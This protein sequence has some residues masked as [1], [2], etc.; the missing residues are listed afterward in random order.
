MADE[1]GDVRMEN[2]QQQERM[3]T[4]EEFRQLQ[5][6]LQQQQ[7]ELQEVRRRNQPENVDNIPRPEGPTSELLRCEK[8]MSMMPKYSR[9]T[10]WRQYVYEW[11]SWVSAFR[12]EQAGDKFIKN[13]M[14][15]SMKGQAQ[16]AIRAHRAGSAT[17]NQ[18]VTWRDYAVAIESIFAPKAESQLAKQEFKGYKQNA[19]EDMTSYFQTKWALFKVA[20]PGD[21]S[22]FDIFHEELIKG[23]CNKEVTGNVA[24]L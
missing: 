12:I 11:E 8:A 16:D 9:T 21:Y 7:Q 15:L 13:A 2:G 4:V 23:I 6:Q 1:D 3:P 22:P 14:I 17:F 18:N 10:P 5:Q 19:T 20:Y 24:N